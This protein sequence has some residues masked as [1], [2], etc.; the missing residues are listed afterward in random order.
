MGEQSGEKGTPRLSIE[1]YDT[2]NGQTYVAVC[3]C[4]WRSSRHGTKSSAIGSAWWHFG[5]CDI[6]PAMTDAT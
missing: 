3:S 1:A 6:P 2:L 4:G 5:K